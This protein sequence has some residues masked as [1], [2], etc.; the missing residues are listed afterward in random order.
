MRY[1]KKSKKKLV[2]ILLIIVV[3]VCSSIFA[4]FNYVVN[5]IILSISESK[6][7]SLSA[8]AVTSAVTEVLASKNIYDELITISTNSDGEI[9][10]IQANSIIINQLTR[11]LARTSQSKL[12]IIGSQGINIPLGSFTGLPVFM[13]RGP[14]IKLRLLPIG[15]IQCSYLSEFKAAG[16]NQTIHKI[17]VNIDSIVNV[18]LPIANK[19]IETA[20]QLLICE[21]IIIGKVPEVYLNSNSLGDMMD[22]IPDRS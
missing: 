18:V 19:K 7:K 5:P 11:D 1:C 12:E 2:I 16:I 4:Y 15:A 17:Y 3:I 21:S 13:G 9:V 20:N 22:L 6:V 14:D 10:L 8:K